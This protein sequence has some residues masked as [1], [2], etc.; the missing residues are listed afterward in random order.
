MVEVKSANPRRAARRDIAA[1]RTAP[2]ELERLRV[3]EFRPAG[4]AHKNAID[5]VDG[6]ARRTLL[7]AVEGQRMDLL[8][9]LGIVHS[10]GASFNAAEDPTPEIHAAF[11]LLEEEIQ[12]VAVG[13]EEDSLRSAM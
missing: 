13:L 7:D 4:S 12:R 11:A 2:N 1:P 9:V 5:F 6:A 10:M 3:S 8:N